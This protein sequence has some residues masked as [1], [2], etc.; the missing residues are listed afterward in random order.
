VSESNEVSFRGY[1][2]SAHAERYTHEYWA[3]KFVVKREGAIIR[4]SDFVTCRNTKPAAE[5]GALI[6]GIQYVDLC[7][8]PMDEFD[9]LRAKVFRRRA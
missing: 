8:K 5:S 6:M 9:A 7:L 4:Q 2:I 3:A 1:E